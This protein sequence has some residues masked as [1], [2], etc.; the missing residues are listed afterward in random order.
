MRFVLAG[1][2]RAAVACLRFLLEKGDDVLAVAVRSDDGRDGWQPSFVRAASQMGVEL[3]Q[4]QRINGPQTVASVVSFHPD[5]LLSLQYDQI[6]RKD[7]LDIP[8]MT[9]LN[10]HF[11]LLPQH[12]GVAPIA[13]AMLEGDE[14][15]GVTLHQMV[16]DIDA[17][18]VLA[19]RS[20][21]I[22]PDA[23]ARELYDDVTDL[24]IGLFQDGYPFDPDLLASGK[25][26]AIGEGCYHRV[27]DFDFSAVDIDWR[28]PAARLYNWMRAMI[29]PP[30]QL[31]ETA[32]DRRTLQVLRVRG[33]IVG[34]DIEPGIVISV[35][36]DGVIVATGD[37]ALDITE[38]SDPADASAS[39]TEILATLRPG[40]PFG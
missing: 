33:P 28:M 18:D 20:V 35:S 7:V 36:D 34:A 24:A 5:I 21:E 2:N 3:I 14:R 6:L 15:A 27:G 10:L 12:Q 4:P 22:I 38:L 39:S 40:L 31:P 1:K 8:G 19:Q 30:L 23:T 37:G 29:F 11:S 26:Q 25:P 16:R 17:G 9:A 32:T 13:W